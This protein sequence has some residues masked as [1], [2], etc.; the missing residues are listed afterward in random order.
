[1]GLNLTI[2][3][4]HAFIEAQMKAYDFNETRNKDL[5][6]KLES[7]N[8]ENEALH[9]LITSLTA[10]KENSKKA[11]FRK[12]DEMRNLIDQVDKINPKIF[13]GM[14]DKYFWENEKKIEITLQAL[15]SQVKMQVSKVSE[16]QMYIGQGFQEIVQYT[17]NA[18]TTL[19]M[20]H[21]HCM[22]ILHRLGK[23]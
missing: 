3:P 13:E 19:K 16:T 1:M 2:N 7:L 9:D 14:K 6:S 17:E 20:L 12:N 22:S 18:I 21:E 15:D 10:Q 4:A 23:Q 11:D 5:I 8:I